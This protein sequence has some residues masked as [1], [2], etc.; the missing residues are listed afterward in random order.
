MQTMTND[1]Y[2]EERLLNFFKEFKSDEDPI[3]PLLD[4]INNFT[5]TQEQFDDMTLLYSKV[6][7]EI[8]KKRVF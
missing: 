3:K 2:G 6:K 5:E 4:D 8:N 1:M 7:R